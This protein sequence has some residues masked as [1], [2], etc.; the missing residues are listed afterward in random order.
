M[1]KEGCLMHID[2]ADNNGKPYLKLM[3]SVRV[4][5]DAGRK[6]SRKELV[7]SIGPL[8]RYD[9]GAPDYIGR[10][11][12]SFKAGQPLIAMLKPYCSKDTPIEKYCFQFD[13]GDTVC[14]GQAKLFSHM[15]LERVV[16]ELGLQNF[17][18][19][20]KGF[21]KI[22]Y[23]VYGFAKL[24]IFGRILNPAS[25]L[26]TTRQNSD[27]YTP[28]LDEGFN[29]DN[30]YDT[31]TFIADNH[32]KI[33]R[34]INTNLVKKASRRPE[35]IYYDVTNFYY[36]TEDPDDDIVDEESGDIIEPGLRKM[37]VCKEKLKQPIVQMGLFMDDDGLPITVEVF[38]GNT[39]DH[40]TLQKALNRSIDGLELS[41]FILVGDRGVC[42]GPAILN[43][44]DDGNGYIFAKS[45][46]K[47]SASE[48]A[49]IYSEQDYIHDGPG[50][51]YKSKIRRRKVKGEDGETREITENVVAYWSEKYAKRAA[52]ENKSFLEFLDRLIESP[53]NFR[54]T[55]L[56]AKKLRGFLSKNIVN[57]KTGEVL[58]SS[59]WRALVDIGKI[60]TYKKS[61]GYYQIVTSELT[62]D[63][64]SV[65]GKYRGLSQIE[66][67]FNIMKGSLETRPLYVRNPEHVSA[68][69]LICMI[70][71]TVLRI[72]QN[73]I[74]K[75]CL[76]PSA[77]E[78]GVSWTMGLSGERVQN[79]LN[80]WQVDKLPSDHYRF[81]NIYDPDLKLILDSFDIKIPLKLFR[82][83]DLKQLKTGINIF[84]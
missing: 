20:Y 80:K 18:S 6:V 34:R 26:A 36:H 58:S 63:A 15:L 78:K 66:K 13:E 22:R 74:V 52:K 61:F 50:F 76:V 33:I 23:D 10:L 28:V 9:D 47:S 62:M 25:K 37:G 68:H 32:D 56:Q 82:R 51:K 29:P 49:W 53:A 84:M 70:A 31:L 45:V 16:E 8:D 75:S 19:A 81:L 1:E 27:Y 44:L 59:E 12:K 83:A 72:I 41:R 24:M 5:N 64:K 79:A 14:F 17:F 7:K 43:L 48:R 46:L 39:L 42:I 69:L 77:G 67:Q 11:R 21:T 3:K 30:I 65:I 60:E 57:E 4:E 38:P 2:V 40:Q 35:V 71:L 73:R 54:V 55:A